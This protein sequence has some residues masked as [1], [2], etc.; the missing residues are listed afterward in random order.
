MIEKVFFLLF[1]VLIVIIMFGIYGA[2]LEFIFGVLKGLGWDS[3]NAASML[4]GILF[5]YSGRWFDK[6]CEKELEK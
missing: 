3:G 5:G 2:L 6:I 4:T 1:A